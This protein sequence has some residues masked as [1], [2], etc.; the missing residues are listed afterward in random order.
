MLKII[1]LSA[2]CKDIYENIQYLLKNTQAS[3]IGVIENC[4]DEI[5]LNEEEVRFLNNG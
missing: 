1:I 2:L 4:S 5:L 3:L